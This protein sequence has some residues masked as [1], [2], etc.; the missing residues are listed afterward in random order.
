MSKHYIILED[1]AKGIAVTGLTQTSAEHAV[2]GTQTPAMQLGEFL[3][4]AAQLWIN[5]QHLDIQDAI[6]YVEKCAT[7]PLK[8]IVKH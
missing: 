6:K 3:K 1:T 5:T 7:K 4:S 2:N 8:N